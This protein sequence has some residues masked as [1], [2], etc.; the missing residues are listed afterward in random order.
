MSQK[1]GRTWHVA[2][3]G[4]TNFKLVDGKCIEHVLKTKHDNYVKILSPFDRTIWFEITGN[5]GLLMLQD[6]KWKSGRKV[7]SH[8]FSTKVLAGHME[9]V[10][11]KNGRLLLDRLDK[12]EKGKAVDMQD[13]FFRYTM[14]S[15]CEIAYGIS[16][17]SLVADG[18]K[19]SAFSQAF[20]RM[21]MR[22]VARRIEP[23]FIAK[24]KLA[25]R[26]TADEKQ[27]KEDEK[28]INDFIYP[29]VAKRRQEHKDD[30]ANPLIETKTFKGDLITL[31][32]DYAKKQG[33]EISDESLRDQCTTMLL[34]GRDTTASVLTS[35][36][37]MLSKHPDVEEKVVKEIQQEIGEATPTHDNIKGLTYCEA[38]F[39]EALRL[40]PAAPLN[41]RKCRT[42]DTL[43]D[44]TYIPAGSE[45][46]WLPWV[47]GHDPKLYPEPDT[48][49][50]ERWLGDKTSPSAPAPLHLFDNP[51]FNAGPRVCLG[52]AMSYLEARMLMVLIL[53]KYRLKLIPG[54]KLDEYELGLTLVREHGQLMNLIPSSISS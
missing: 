31:F 44:G 28:T 37:Q 14:D 54:Q 52:K 17:N 20:D 41:Y 2:V 26:L 21:Q 12:V 46:Q 3:P 48:F 22:I 47:C 27:A 15:F 5:D 39:N 38:V 51:A 8:L 43:P 11:L 7:A 53:Q 16:P 19:P 18:D 33:E 32:V 10:F 35:I 25:L 49:K 24:I 13:L 4:R 9:A 30:A 34:A 6:Q 42:A 45:V 29:A 1:F 36:F 40:F 50:P 23:S